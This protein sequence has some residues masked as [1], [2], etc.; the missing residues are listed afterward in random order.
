MSTRA[1]T[2][3]KEIEM[4]V[5]LCAAVRQSGGDD[6]RNGEED[7]LNEDKG[8]VGEYSRVWTSGG[9]AQWQSNGDGGALPH[10]R[11]LDSRTT[12]R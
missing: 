3:D 12:K 2:P 11:R 6:R 5:G 4:C 1:R 10:A 8:R 9:S 7:G